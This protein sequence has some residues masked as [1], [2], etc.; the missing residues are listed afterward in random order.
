M[1]FFNFSDRK[2]RIAARTQKFPRPSPIN[3]EELIEKRIK[4][5]KDSSFVFLTYAFPRS[6]E[7][8]GP[9]LFL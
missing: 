9:Y 4:K 7:R 6:S 3:I 5:F 2:K 8:F 1:K